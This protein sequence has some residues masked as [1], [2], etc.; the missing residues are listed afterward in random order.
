MFGV[1]SVRPTH[2]AKAFV[3]LLLAGFLISCGSGDTDGGPGND[4]ANPTGNPYVSDGG[5]GGSIFLT[6]DQEIGVGEIK[7][8]ILSLRDSNGQP[9]PFVRTYCDTERGIAIIEPNRG[10]AAYEH[11]S[12]NG[13]MS[14]RFGGALPGSYIIECRGPVGYGLIVRKTLK[15]VGPVPAGFGGFSGAAGG[16]L[17]GGTFVD[18]DD[19]ED[20]GSRVTGL[21]FNDNTS[22]SAGDTV[23]ITLGVCD[24]DAEP[25][26][27]TTAEI[28]V[29]NDSSETLFI[30]SATIDTDY[31][32][33][34]A[35]VIRQSRLPVELEIEAGATGIVK[36][37]YLNV[38][39]ARTSKQFAGLGSAVSAGVAEVTATVAGRNESGGAIAI[40]GTSTVVFANYNRCS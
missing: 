2:I 7:E 33:P 22:G 1:N 4:A 19:I 6:M 17:G 15:V 16:N 38:N 35:A 32:S 25:F 24:S 9:L 30:E 18:S 21:A 14:G 10:G 36:V 27:N 39:G 12:A 28:S 26:T 40:S 3:S 13:N 8:F 34:D 11:T 23:D 31:T 20:R 29:K 37:V 5:A